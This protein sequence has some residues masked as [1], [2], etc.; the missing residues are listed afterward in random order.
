[1]H[2][3]YRALAFQL[4]DDQTVV[5]ALGRNEHSLT[6]LIVHR[7]TSSKQVELGVCRKNPEAIMLASERLNSRTLCQVPDADSLVLATRNDQFVFR[8][9][10]RGRDV[11]EV[12]AAG[13]DFPSPVLAHTP[14]LDLS[15]ISSR[16]D[17]R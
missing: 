3:K 15:V 6:Y 7:R 9:E 2:R 1:M 16:D 14:D 12:A 13:I 4:E 5:V 17:Q 10:E 11:I 8:V